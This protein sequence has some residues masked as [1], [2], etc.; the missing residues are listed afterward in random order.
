M[1]AILGL[2]SDD[3]AHRVVQYVLGY[4][5][6]LDWDVLPFLLYMAVTTSKGSSICSFYLNLG[7]LYMR[8]ET[9]W[10]TNFTPTG[11]NLKRKAV[12]KQHSYKTALGV[13]SFGRIFAVYRCHQILN[14]AVNEVFKWVSFH[15]VSI[16]VAIA[17]PAFG[18]IR[19][20]YEVEWFEMQ[21]LGWRRSQ[22]AWYFGLK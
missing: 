4:S 3:T 14:R 10:L 9:F 5:P 12:L 17:F 6:R 13:V 20:S 2:N 21:L 15:F 18:L 7:I 16:I 11:I 19:F 1:V 8:L 22:L